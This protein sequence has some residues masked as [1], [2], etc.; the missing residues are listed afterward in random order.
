LM[1]VEVEI[2]VAP[3]LRIELAV[4]MYDDLVKSSLIDSFSLG[5]RYE[6]CMQSILRGHLDFI[7]SLLREFDYTYRSYRHDGDTVVHALA[8]YSQAQVLELLPEEAHTAID[9]KN[10]LEE[11]A[12]MISSRM[13]DVR[14]ARIL[15]AIKASV[16]VVSSAGLSCLHIAAEMGH[17]SMVELLL[18]H[19]ADV[20]ASCERGG[21]SYTPLLFAQ[22]NRN[23]SAVELLEDAMAISATS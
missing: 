1:A 19:K 9:L 18:Q 13:G 14:V 16:H 8:R 20:R 23:Q 15:L 7:I 21:E 11:T 12:L 17:V 5:L 3:A 22:S 2:H 6:L 4:S 10:N